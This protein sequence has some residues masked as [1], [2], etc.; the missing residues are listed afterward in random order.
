MI[1]AKSKLCFISGRVESALLAAV[2][3]RK[4]R[5]QTK[6]IWFGL[7]TEYGGSWRLTYKKETAY[8]DDV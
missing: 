5:Q 4:Y 6:Q 2:L 3:V 1:Q 7:T 8:I